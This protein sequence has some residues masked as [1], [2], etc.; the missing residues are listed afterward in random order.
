V[1]KKQFEIFVEPPDAIILQKKKIGLYWKVFEV[2]TVL[3]N[4]ADEKALT[5]AKQQLGG[6][7]G[8]N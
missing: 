7:F 4:Y 2:K 1:Q 5:G 3:P 6:N 8:G